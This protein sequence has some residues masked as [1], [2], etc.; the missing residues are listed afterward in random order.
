MPL[1]DMLLCCLSKKDFLLYLNSEITLNKKKKEEIEAV[2]NNTALTQKVAVQIQELLDE[3][4]TLRNNLN[5]QY[6]GCL[7]AYGKDFM[8]LQKEQQLQLGVLVNNTKSL[9]TSLSKS[10]Q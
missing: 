1:K 5:H 4:I 10:I 9:A 3:V 7:S 6:S 8:S 2:K